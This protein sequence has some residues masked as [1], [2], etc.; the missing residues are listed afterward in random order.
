METTLQPVG[1]RQ[2]KSQF[3]A[4]AEE[5]NRLGEPLTVMRHNKPWVVISPADTA[6]MERRRRLKAFHDLTARI[7]ADDEGGAWGSLEEDE[8]LLEEGRSVRFG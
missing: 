3:S 4:L 5:V 6:A 2:A 7:E 1:V 8:R